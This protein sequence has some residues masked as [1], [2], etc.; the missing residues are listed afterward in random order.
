MIF[1]KNFILSTVLVFLMLGCGS[2]DSPKDQNSSAFQKA[3]VDSS[4]EILKEDDNKTEIV[5]SL[6][7]VEEPLICSL[8][9]RKKFVHDVIH[10]SYFWADDAPDLDFLSDNY[11][12]SKELLLALKDNRDRFSFIADAKDIDGY[13]DGGKN[14]NFGFDFVI[15]SYGN[16]MEYWVVNYV[17]PNSPADKAGITRSTMI[18]GINDE[19]IRTENRTDL[20]K[21][22]Y[23]EDKITLNITYPSNRKII[24]EKSS[25][26]IDTIL[27][28]DVFLSEDRSTKIGYFVFQ[29]FIEKATDDLDNLFSFLKRDN[30]NELIVDLRY[31]RGGYMH[32]ATH[33]ASLI[34]GN[35]ASDKIFYQSVFN[36]KYQDYNYNKTFKKDLSNSLDLDRVFIITTKATCSASEAVINGLKAS[37]SGVEV[38]QVGDSTCGKPHGYYGLSFCDKYLF[39]VNF[40]VQNGDGDGDYVYGIS[41]T[42]KAYD[43]TKYNFGDT[44]EDSLKEV[45]Y[46]I[47]NGRCSFRTRSDR[48]VKNLISPKKEGFGNIMSAY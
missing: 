8:N 5:E 46:Y 38:I 3:N 13:F 15:G 48:S 6:F 32:V 27:Y 43:D 36:Q 19:S 7:D 11:Q 21:L 41:P 18:N 37:L 16:G 23:D 28:R 12:D 31:N 30:I 22:F 29:D 47:D 44:R 34:A 33:L 24:L 35:S 42:C 26:E 45:L 2:S 9:N 40:E 20:I 17:Y 25:Y 4:K 39:A 10:D 1:L 14:S